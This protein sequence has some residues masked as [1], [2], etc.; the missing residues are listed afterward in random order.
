MELFIFRIRIEISDIIEEYR[1][2]DVL[3]IAIVISD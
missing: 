1:S 2:I 3:G